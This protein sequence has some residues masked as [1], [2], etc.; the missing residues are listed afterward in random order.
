M[1]E[2]VFDSDIRAAVADTEKEILAE[3]FGDEEPSDQD[4]QLIDDLS[5]TEGW[6]GGDLPDEEAWNRTLHGDTQT[7]YD[8]P[9]EMENEQTLAATN[10]LLRQQIAEQEQFIQGYLA[11]PLT[12]EARAAQRNAVRANLEQRYGMIHAGG[13]A[14]FD[15]F[16]GDVQ[17]ALQHTSALENGRVGASLQHAHSQYGQDFV[18]AFSDLTSMDP[19]HPLARQL[20][21]SVVASAD[22]GQAVMQLHGNDI[23]RSLSTGNVP[24][25]V[26]RPRNMAPAFVRSGPARDQG[27]TSGYGDRDTEADIFNSTWED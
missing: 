22:P 12:D 4:S 8:R 16:V 11:K 10:D 18:D 3:A 9:L 21:Q 23:V 6:D 26:P 2:T 13:D 7:G 14:K 24:P 20:V 1:D 15:Q 5:Q 17:S 25:F 19:R 27:W